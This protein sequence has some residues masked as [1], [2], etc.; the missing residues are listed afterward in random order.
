M[1]KFTGEVPRLAYRNQI[2]Y[3]L[4]EE[5]IMAIN[6]EG[7]MRQ[8]I[9]ADEGF[10]FSDFDIVYDEKSRT[11][12]LTVLGSSL[13]SPRTGRIWLHPLEDH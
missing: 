2:F 11:A 6:T 8:S 3:I 4:R 5:E 7:E 10:E 13:S 12:A 9:A 1:A